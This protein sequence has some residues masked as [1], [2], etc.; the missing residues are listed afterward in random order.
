METRGELARSTRRREKEK[1]GKRVGMYGE[2][3]AGIVLCV[4]ARA[5]R[6]FAAVFSVVAFGC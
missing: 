6:G 5:S 2:I 4:R 3:D 1:R